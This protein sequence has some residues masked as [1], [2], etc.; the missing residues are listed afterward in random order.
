MTAS[1]ERGGTTAASPHA[2]FIPREEL[3]EFS[4]WRPDAFGDTGGGAASP[5]DPRRSAAQQAA[6]QSA[7]Q[8]GYQDGYRDGLVALESFKQS[9]ATQMAAQIGAIVAA[10]D[11]EFMQLESQIADTVARTA[12]ALAR[13]V[14]RSEL[15]TR[16]ELV[17]AVAAQAVEAVLLSAKHIR[18]HV[19][20]D[21][22]AL[23]ASGADEVLRARGAR[24]LSDPR[25]SRGGCVVESEL[26][27]IDAGIEARWA[28]AAAA[29]G[30]PLPLD[31]GAEG[32]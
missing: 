31:D 5:D 10:F 22:Q 4:S 20:P 16:P 29:L 11:A 8:A 13:Q 1:S 25:I 19:H 24:L 3:S 9:F 32:T 23:V 30:Q 17:A 12:T 6:V 27:R 18:L 21:D 26:G 7:R 2:R 14:V 15:S 28:Q